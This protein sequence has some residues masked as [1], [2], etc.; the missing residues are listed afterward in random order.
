MERS[1]RK[2]LAESTGSALE[3]KSYSQHPK[4]FNMTSLL[5]LFTFLNLLCVQ[6]VSQMST[7][8]SFA[9]SMG[10]GGRKVRVR[11]GVSL[12]VG[13]VAYGVGTVART[14]AR[15]VRDGAGMII[16]SSLSGDLGDGMGVDGVDHR[17]SG[18]RYD[19]YIHAGVGVRYTWTLGIFSFFVPVSS[20]RCVSHLCVFGRT[21]CGGDGGR[22]HS[23]SGGGDGGGESAAFPD[24]AGGRGSGRDD[25]E[26]AGREIAAIGV[27]CSGSGGMS[28][29]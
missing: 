17:S 15:A 7:D 4:L 6:I 18:D 13:T 8:S 5:Y 28:C 24:A 11:E 23:G 9:W 16:P 22:S 21:P 29:L 12:G 27:A 1:T 3:G 14:G 20:G 26:N 19:T 2:F 10:P 25:G